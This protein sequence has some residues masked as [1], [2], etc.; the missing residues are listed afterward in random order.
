[1]IKLEI[2]IFDRTTPWT[3]V[4]DEHRATFFCH[5]STP[6]EFSVPAEELLQHATPLA[7]DHL[8]KA[9][10]GG[11]TRV[12]RVGEGPWQRLEEFFLGF[13]DELVSQQLKLRATTASLLAPWAIGE[14]VFSWQSFAVPVAILLGLQWVA[15]R[16]VRRVS[17]LVAATTFLVLA[18]LTD[19]L[20]KLTWGSAWIQWVLPAA[21]VAIALGHWKT[22][23]WLTQSASPSGME[24]A[25]A[26]LVGF[27][28][29]LGVGAWGYFFGGWD[30]WLWLTAP[31]W[32]PQPDFDS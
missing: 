15:A 28:A 6:S 13:G 11:K 25:A 16:F 21:M 2:D 29:L 5:G 26:V 3:M 20:I 30:V 19:G 23:R 8:L 7:G 9:S 31:E 17:A 1:M 10:V 4:V 27:L 14:V 24:L 12:F 32:A 22:Y 18:A